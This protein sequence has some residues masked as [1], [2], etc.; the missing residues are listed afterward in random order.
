MSQQH[1]RYVGTED[2]ERGLVPT[3]LRGVPVITG[4]AIAA[5]LL[6][7]SQGLLGWTERLSSSPKNAWIASRA[8]DW[9]DLMTSIGLAQPMQHIRAWL[10]D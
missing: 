9:H 1:E 8:A 5:L 2:L 6:F 4:I 10:S 3:P 7:N